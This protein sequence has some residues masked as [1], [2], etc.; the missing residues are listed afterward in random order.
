MPRVRAAFTDGPAHSAPSG[1][2]KDVGLLKGFQA[3]EV[4][5]TPQQDGLT[6]FHCHQQMHRGQGF[7]KLLKVV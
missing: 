1:I 6:L 7:K 4:D 2:H 3:A 5:F